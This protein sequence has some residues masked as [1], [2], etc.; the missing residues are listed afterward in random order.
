MRAGVVH[1]D[2]IATA[3]RQQV[4]YGGR[5]GTNL[6][7]LGYATQDEVAHGLA[8]LH[9]VPAALEKHLARHDER[10]LSLLPRAL[11]ARFVA[12]PVALAMSGGEKR[13]VVCFRDPKQPAALEEIAQATQLPVVACVAPE[14]AVLYWLERGYGIPRSRRMVAAR[15]GKSLPIPPSRSEILPAVTRESDGSVDVDMD[16]DDEASLPTELQLV[17]LDHSDVEKDLSQYSL[18][19]KQTSLAEL[20][21]RAHRADQEPIGLAAAI[22]I[23]ALAAAGAAAARAAAAALAEADAEPAPAPEPET[24]SQK[25]DARNQTPASRHQTPDTSEQKPETRNQ[26]PETRNQ[27]PETRSQ[28]P[29]TSKQRTATEP[30]HSGV[31]DGWNVDPPPSVSVSHAVARIA[32]ADDREDVL[33]ATLD[34]MRGILGAGLVVTAKDELALGHKGFGGHFDDDSVESIVIPLSVPSVFH[35]PY[36]NRR[37]FH[38]PPPGDGHAIQERF[39]KLF[40]LETTPSDV[41]VTPV[42]VRNRVVC[43]F[44]GHGHGGGPISDDTVAALAE[45]ATASGDAFVRLIR[46]AKQK[47]TSA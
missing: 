10:L 31:D 7:E 28:K 24:S 3:M 36:V 4:V 43:M 37:P 42:T 34:F 29:D 6:I 21:E 14:L 45:L 11:A 47:P 8:R 1:A 23:D 12:F 13:I 33:D 40:P 39:F 32:A 5:I 22:D 9:G 17:D 18:P 30:A 46:S 15:P 16:L 35:D 27:K 25:P 19:G 44:Y 26:K 2:Q 41:T 20:T 38:G